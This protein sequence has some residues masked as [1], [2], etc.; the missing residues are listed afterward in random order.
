MTSKFNSTVILRHFRRNQLLPF[1]FDS[2][3]MM[4]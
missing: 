3:R 4:G 1:E 2:R